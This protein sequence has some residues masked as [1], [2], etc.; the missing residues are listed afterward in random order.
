VK[1]LVVGLG[2]AGRRLRDAAVQTGCDVASVSRRPGSGEFTSLEDAAAWG[3]EVVVVA[4]PTALHVDALRWAV[5]RGVHVY[6]EKPLASSPRGLQALLDGADRAGLVV[7]TGYNLRFH[8]A[9]EAIKEAV[10]SGRLGRLL[11]VRAE[12]G[13]FLPDWHPESDYR[14]SYAARHDLGGGALFTLSH[15][16]DYVRWIAGEVTNSWGLVRHVSSLELEADDIAEVVLEHEHGA[17]SSVHT[18]FLDRSYNR[19]SRWIGEHA[20][21][22]WDWPGP[23]TL[24]PEGTIL[25]R[26]DSFDL[27]T[28]YL[29]GMDDFIDAVRVGRAARCTGR[30]GLR[31]VELCEAALAGR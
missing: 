29:R 4:T 31:I 24:L 8:P 11:A 18:D 3:A 30:D 14:P 25:W 10:D 22:A 9:L 27:G 7:A 28:T 5:D 20:T 17:L 15:E 6:V 13:Q 16:L 1:A 26:D 2:S 23:V 21:I 19:R 12:A